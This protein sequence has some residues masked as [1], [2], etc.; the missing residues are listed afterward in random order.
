MNLDAVKGAA[1]ITSTLALRGY[2]QT[3]N[4]AG[5]YV[6]DM[7]IQPVNSEM[8]TYTYIPLVGATSVSDANSNISYTEFDGFGRPEYIKD[9]DK[10]IV[11]KFIYKY[12]P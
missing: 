6:D 11:K 12:K 2:V 4:S 10:N 7:R 9:Q 5:F 8:T 1:S 3:N